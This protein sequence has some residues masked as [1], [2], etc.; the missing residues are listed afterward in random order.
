MSML[1]ADPRW[2]TT[3]T[4]VPIFILWAFILVLLF[5]L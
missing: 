3:C 2:A 4:W 1:I 5:A